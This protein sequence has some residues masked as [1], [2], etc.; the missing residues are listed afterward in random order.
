MEGHLARDKETGVFAHGDTVTMA[1]I[2]V[3]AQVAGAGF[4]GVEVGRYPTVKRIAQSCFAIDAFA[5]AHPL[6]Q[7]G[8]PASLGH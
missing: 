3:A 4:F 1:D 5:K 6:K 8:A 2:C 7:P